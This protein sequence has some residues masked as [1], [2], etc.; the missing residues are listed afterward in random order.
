MQ[1]GKGGV[2]ICD[3]SYIDI[4]RS[5]INGDIAADPLFHVMPRYIIFLFATSLLPLFGP[6]E[7]NTNTRRMT[8]LGRRECIMRSDTSTSIPPIRT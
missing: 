2:L 7:E 8:G 3:K 6:K 5:Y 1:V 4:V